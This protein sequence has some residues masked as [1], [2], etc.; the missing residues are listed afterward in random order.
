MRTSQDVK[1]VFRNYGE[2]IVPKDT[3]LTNRT[4]LGIDD[5]YHFVDDLSWIDRDYTTVASILKH[6]AKYYG[7]D[8]PKEFV[9][10]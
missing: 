7:I 6:D 4:A 3:R 1:M 2:I 8:I 9:I 10:K 5:N